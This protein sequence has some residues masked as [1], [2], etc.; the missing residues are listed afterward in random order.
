MKNVAGSLK[1]DLAQYRELE[2]FSQFASELDEATRRQLEK[3]E[4][5][6]ELL[7]Q[8]QYS[9]LHVGAQCLAI[10]AANAGYLRKLEVEEVTDFEDGLYEFA[11]SKDPE[12]YEKIKNDED[13]GD[14]W[15]SDPS[16]VTE[17]ALSIIE[18]YS[19]NY[20]AQQQDQEAAAE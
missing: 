17:H 15:E 6:V 16:D 10:L 11:E 9:P 3:G 19:E 12:L 20:H 1:L 18:E 13:F 8:D 14:D 5:L 7:K 2:A 4:R